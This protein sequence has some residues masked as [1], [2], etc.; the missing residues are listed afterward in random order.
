MIIFVFAMYI[1][2]LAELIY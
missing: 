2:P 1:Y